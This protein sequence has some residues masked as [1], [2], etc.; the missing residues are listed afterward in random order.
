MSGDGIAPDPGRVTTVQNWPRPKNLTEVRS[1]LGLASYYRR[2][3]E[4]FA[5]I[6]R[7]LHYL[8]RKDVPFHWGPEQQGAF[9]ELK[10][11]LVSAPLVAAPRKDGL[12]TLDTDASNEAIGAVLQQE[13]DGRTV[14]IAYAS[15]RLSDAE[16]RYTV[17]K[18]ELL[19][20]VY[21]L[22]EFR[23]YLLCRKFLLRTDHAALTFLMKTP[24]LP[25]QQVRWLDLIAE[26]NFE[27]V[28]RAGAQHNN[29]DSLSRRPPD[30]DD[31]ETALKRPMESRQCSFKAAPIERTAVD[32]ER[33]IHLDLEGIR[34]AQKDDPVIQTV[35]QW[36][37]SAEDDPDG[38]RVQ[39]A[40]LKVQQLW[41]QNETLEIVEEV[42]YRRFVDTERT[43]KW[44]QIIL[45]ASLVNEF[46]T[47]IHGGPASGHF[48]VEKTQRAV[49]KYAYWPGWKTD[50]ETFVRKCDVCC[51]YRRGPRHRQ[52]P[53]QEAT[54]FGAMR[55][56][57][58]DLTGPHPRSKNGFTYI[59]TV[60]CQ[61]TKYLI[62]VP[63]RDKTAL[64]VARALV[65]HVY[66]VYGAAEL[67]ISDNGKE[68]VNEIEGIVGH[69]LTNSIT[70]S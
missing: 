13:Q 1:F 68:F 18:K 20:I 23:H 67:Q 14:V 24:D 16:Y 41:S 28:H 35:R 6:A 54:S 43:L 46:V 60:I 12:F 50:V 53:L 51:R 11:R 70:L 42:L 3:V 44:R 33:L 29:A 52:G 34:Q 69:L 27:I 66:L 61:F 47:K 31:E 4:H 65:K 7:P 22:K 37:E 55:K 39:R 45:P 59:L 5:E 40:P 64:S 49:Q 2:S 30:D 8:M 19:A 26:Y 9:D 48:G 17:T 62:A 15:R 32:A 57:H 56:V 36:I 25:S 10:R 58:I 63:L 38:R 21:G